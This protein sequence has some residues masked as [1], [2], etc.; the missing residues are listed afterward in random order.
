MA[1]ISLSGLASGLDTSSIIS[2]LMAL[3]Q[4][5]VTAV[6]MRQVKVQAHKD[7]LSSIKT[8]LDAFKSAATAL[9]D[10]A[11]W[12][13]TQTSA[14]SDTT[15][16][17]VALLS[18]A[19]I[20]G[21][22]VKIDKLASSAQHGFTYT[23]SA[24]AGTLD[25]AYAPTAAN[26]T[27]TTSTI[28]IAA[29]ATA[30]DIA[31]AINAK[32]DSPAY[33]AVIKDSGGNERIVLSAR[34]TGEDS[35][36]TLDPANM[37]AGSSLVEDGTYSRT[38]TTLNAS[39]WLDDEATARSSQSNIVENAV[40]GV[41]LTLKGITSSPLSVTTTAAAIDTAGV[42]KKVQALVDAYNS[43][44]SATRTQLTEKSDPKATTT[45]GL[46]A[47]TLFGDSGLNSMLSSLKGQMTQVVTGLGL[48]SLADLGINV[49]KS[50]GG[51]STQEAKDGKMSFD[52]TK[53]T[54]ALNADWTKVR[55][56]FSGKGTTKGIS[57]KISDYVGTQTG[58]NGVLTGR[59]TSD[60]SILKDFTNQITRLNDR[61]TS[62]EAR[63]KAQFTAMET[64]LNNSQTQQ[65][66]L[67]SQISSLPSLG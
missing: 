48:T 62:T 15:K 28:S 34:K 29:N 61:M 1:G 20:G 67:T 44:V 6:Q 2:Q 19:G 4:N 66:W 10:A 51:A 16:L 18:G 50:T 32:E 56:L 11:T 7:D 27:P 47:G 14:S 59:M 55:D 39:Y 9:S 65:A 21:H 58:T 25:L 54:D 24:T 5:K 37:G 63:L 49:P 26:P 8:K 53:F 38:G 42:Q 40:P 31:T 64:A 43:V 22:T 52:T 46:S 35:N 17:D 12:K 41:R 36:F 23:P 13:A 30:A 33:A 45:S 57:A 60:D 3:E